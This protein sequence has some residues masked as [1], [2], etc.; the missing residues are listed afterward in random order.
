M[1][2]NLAEKQ[3]RK[4]RSATELGVTYVNVRESSARRESDRDS[5]SD[6]S[7]DVNLSVI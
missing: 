7:V 2:F 5:S 3:Q 1:V 4:L 6:E